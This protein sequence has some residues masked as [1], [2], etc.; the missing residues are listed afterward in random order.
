MLR[1]EAARA[2]GFN[3]NEHPCREP[4]YILIGSTR[5]Q[6]LESEQSRQPNSLRN[7]GSIINYISGLGARSSWRKRLVD[8]RRGVSYYVCALDS[9]LFSSC[10]KFNVVP[11][12]KIQGRFTTDGSSAA[13]T[14]LTSFQG[15]ALQRCN[16]FNVVPGGKIQGRFTTAGSSAAV[17]SLTSFQGGKF[18]VVSLQPALQRCDKFNV[19][20][21]DWCC[22][23]NGTACMRCFHLKLHSANVLQV[24]TCPTCLDQC[25]LTEEA[26]RHTCPTGDY[27]QR[28]YFKEIT[29]FREY[30]FTIMWIRRCF[31][32]T[33]SPPNNKM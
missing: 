28:N 26:A 20:P 33:K 30:R 19:V 7:Q 22:S 12:G 8:F 1:S 25:Y 10:D 21:G 15:S 18:K 27:F 11:G 16:K 4:N 31:I 29:L 13:V 3:N 9:R 17:I 2:L 6:K 14:S 23:F 32:A 5:T 24:H